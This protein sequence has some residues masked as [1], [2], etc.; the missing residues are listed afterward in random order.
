M[1]YKN[2]SCVFMYKYHTLTD[3]PTGAPNLC[4]FNPWKQLVPGHGVYAPPII[5]CQF[6]S[7]VHFLFYPSPQLLFFTGGVSLWCPGC[8]W[9]SRLNWSSHL[10]LWV[11]ETTG[12]CHHAWLLLSPLAQQVFLES[13][14]YSSSA[15]ATTRSYF[16]YLRV[17]LYLRVHI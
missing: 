10:N 11:A 5:L 7:L 8:T 14:P 6:F 2:V 12:V 15:Q 9:T 17:A 1:T 3:C 16:T 4:L 13:S